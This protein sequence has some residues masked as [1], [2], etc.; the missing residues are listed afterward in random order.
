MTAPD[1]GKT[2]IVRNHRANVFGV[3]F[4]Q[5]NEPA[6]VAHVFSELEQ[7][8]GGWMVT[9]NLHILREVTRDPEVARLVRSAPLV[10]MDGAPVEWAGRLARRTTV[11]R[12]PG[13]T[14]FWSLNAAAASRGVGVLL[15]GGRPGSADLAAAKLESLYPAIDVRSHFPPFGF[16][17]DPAAR[18]EILDAVR[19]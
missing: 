19:V 18:A 12:V 2:Q 16:E 17:S 15:V 14:V 11:A 7:G 8:R 10:V 3:H 6:V 9:P 1:V 13:S 5:M 4:D